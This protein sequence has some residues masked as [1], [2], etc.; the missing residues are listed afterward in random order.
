M[1]GLQFSHSQR[2][3]YLLWTAP[4][5]LFGALF[6][7]PIF[8]IFELG[9]G[10]NFLN[11]L[12]S[13]ENAR[14]TL[15][16]LWQ[17]LLSMIL[18]LLLATPIAYS[19]YKVKFRGQTLLSAVVTLPF[20]L[21][22]IVVGIGFTSTLKG[23]SPILL[24][25]TANTFMNS[26]LAA[27]IIGSTWQSIGN[28][29]TDSAALDGAGKVRIFFSIT[30][31]QLRGAYAAAGFLI[32]LYCSANFGIILVLGDEKTRSIETSIYVSA[33]ENLDLSRA[34]GLVLIQTILTLLLFLAISKFSGLAVN[35]FGAH[36]RSTNR[37]ARVEDLPT[38]LFSIGT[39]ALLVIVPLASI[40]WRSMHYESHLTLQNFHNLA[41]T[42]ARDALNITL[43][44][45]LLN[46]FRNAGIGLVISVGFGLFIA[47]LLTRSRHR[48]LGAIFQIPLGVSSVVLGLGYLITFSD[49]L[50]PLRSSWLVTPI[51]QSMVLIPLFLQI[52]LPALRIIGDD[53]R[54]SAE[55]DGCNQLTYWWL[56]ELPLIKG[57][58]ILA[59]VY[60]LVISLGELGAANFLAYGDQATL[61][62]VLF[63]LISH[64][65]PL[66]YGMALAAGSIFIFLAGLL[67]SLSGL[68]SLSRQKIPSNSVKL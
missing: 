27:R 6:Y 34:A 39:A 68:T 46:S 62:S 14:I 19:L 64:P 5:F 35:P 16:T 55:I 33:V 67:I 18:S 12:L 38:V 28:D 8:R 11:Q 26:G 47:F 61:P 60:V 66:N 49:G 41:T 20:V 17:A 37:R 42:G 32:F 30:L 53:L 45:A 58:I 25:I 52:T 51:A 24:I 22:T 65:G 48:H 50:F 36:E 56:V 3:H 59:S 23:A 29:E 1:P 31:V 15:F 57:T 4:L 63:Q 54:E 40:F 44:Q 43:L 7:Q 21:P 10:H 13:A 2:G 9:I